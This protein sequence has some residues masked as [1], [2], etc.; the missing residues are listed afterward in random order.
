MKVRTQLIILLLILIAV[1][2]YLVVDALS[3]GF[4][5]E[6]SWYQS[7]ITGLM[8]LIC[9]YWVFLPD[10]KLNQK[11]RFRSRGEIHDEVFKEHQDSWERRYY[12]F[13]DDLQ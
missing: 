12:H 1:T 6:A 7:A 3:G 9:L 13:P 8:S 11:I 4:F 2:A 5:A 10:E